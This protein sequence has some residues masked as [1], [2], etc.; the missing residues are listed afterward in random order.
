MVPLHAVRKPEDIA[1]KFSVR[2]RQGRAYQ[3]LF[4]NFIREWLPQTIL[5]VKT[6]G[7]TQAHPHAAAH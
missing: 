1:S 3:K 5:E 6:H 2:V 4:T 7:I